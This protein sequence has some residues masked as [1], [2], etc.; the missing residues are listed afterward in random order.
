MLWHVSIGFSNDPKACWHF[1][2]PTVI[3]SSSRFKGLSFYKKS[4]WGGIVHPWQLGGSEADVHRTKGDDTWLCLWTLG[5]DTG[6]SLYLDIR[7]GREW[8]LDVFF[9][10]GLPR[11]ADWDLLRDL[12][13]LFSL[14]WCMPEGLLWRWRLSIGKCE[15]RY[16]T[17]VA[18]LF[19]K[20]TSY[21]FTYYMLT[22]KLI[23]K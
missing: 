14:R 13:G 5:K 22:K 17:F 2:L 8:A 12:G 21:L 15:F 3:L 18:S 4:A 7:R 20:K 6:R 19:K 11:C 10:P 16:T 9:A 1:W 23:R